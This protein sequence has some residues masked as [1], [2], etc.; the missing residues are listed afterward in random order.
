MKLPLC[1]DEA[2]N[3]KIDKKMFQVLLLKKMEI[4]FFLLCRFNNSVMGTE[5]CQAKKWMK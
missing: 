2:K 3:L 5:R 1:E 4:F